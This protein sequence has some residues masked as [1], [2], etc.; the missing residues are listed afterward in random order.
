MWNL[1]SNSKY[2]RIERVVKKE[3]LGKCNSPW[4]SFFDGPQKMNWN[5][6]LMG[7]LEKDQALEGTTWNCWS[8]TTEENF[9]SLYEKGTAIHWQWDYGSIESEWG[10]HDETFDFDSLFLVWSDRE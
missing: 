10:N 8:W 6:S 3:E 4:E 9:D 7:P 2:T 5:Y 1:N